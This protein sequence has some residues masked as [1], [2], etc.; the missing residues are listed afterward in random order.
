MY[1][2]IE[3]EVAGG[4]GPDID[5]D[6][7]RKPRLT[8]PLHYEFAGWLGDD[9][10]TTAGYWIVSAPLAAA[11]RTSGL[12]G[13]E[14]AEVVV[15]KEEQFDMLPLRRPFPEWVRLVPTGR[16]STGED[17]VVD[18]GTE[19]LISDATLD[20]FRGFHLA[21]AVV[22][23]G[24]QPSA[25]D[26][27]PGEEAGTAPLAGSYFRLS[28]ARTGSLAE[29]CDYDHRRKPA[30]VGPLYFE[31]D[32]ALQDDIG[33][34][35]G[36]QIVTAALAK[37][38]V[39]SDL[40]GFDLGAVVASVEDGFEGAEATAVLAEEW[41]HLIASETFDDGADFVRPS[42]NVLLVSEAAFELLKGFR[43]T[44]VR[45]YTDAGMPIEDAWGAADVG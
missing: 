2:H 1:H 20:L 7:G 23:S 35:Y 22:T 33:G 39:E 9:V 32:C 36:Y 5:Y 10:V 6:R 44:E 38:L 3:A 27:V 28:P 11:L 31:F 43:H 14:L 13:F 45:V 34:T 18:Q 29:E 41:K 26:R 37:A 25:D 21:E 12:T 8:G 4:F 24:V 19:L 30:L 42:R 40:T 15:T 16:G 17:V